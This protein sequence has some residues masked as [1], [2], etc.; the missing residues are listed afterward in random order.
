MQIFLSRL[1][2]VRPE[3]QKQ[4]FLLATILFA[5]MAGLEM[6]SNVAELTFVRRVGVEFLPRLYSFEPI[7]LIGLLLFFGSAIDR[8]GRYRVLFAL[9]GGLALALLLARAL[10]QVN[11]YPIF[12]TLWLAQRIFYGLAPLSF[13]VLCNDVFDIRQSKRLFPSI[14]AAGLAGVTLGNLLTGVLSAWFTAED[15]VLVAAL[16]FG[17]GIIAVEGVRRLKLPPSFVH[18]D[19]MRDKKVSITLPAHL[20]TQPFLQALFLL[21]FILGALEPVLR[22]ELNALA[23]QTFSAE[24]SLISFVGFIKASGAF[25]IV[26]FQLLVA[27]R[28]LDRAGVPATLNILPIGFMILLPLL[29]LFPNIIIGSFVV[30]TL[31]T[32]AAGFHGPAR[33]SALNLFPP[34]ERGRISAF[35]DQLWYVGWFCNSLFLSWASTHLTL[36]QINFAAALIAALWLFILPSLHRRYIDACLKNVSLPIDEAIKSFREIGIKDSRFE[37]G[38]SHAALRSSSPYQRRAVMRTLSPRLSENSHNAEAITTQLQP[39]FRLMVLT[40]PLESALWSKIT[41]EFGQSCARAS[42]ALLELTHDPKQIRAVRRMIGNESPAMRAAGIEALDGLVRL[43]GIKQHLIMLISDA[44]LEEKRAYG[45]KWLKIE[46]AATPEESLRQLSQFPDPTVRLWSQRQLNRNEDPSVELAIKIDSLRRA[47]AFASLT[48][49]ELK[50]VALCAREHQF[51]KGQMICEEGQASVALY[52]IVAGEVELESAARRQ[53]VKRLKEGDTFGE[54][55]MLGDQPYALTTMAL[56]NVSTLII[57]RDTLKELIEYYPNI[58]LG[59][60]RELALRLGQSLDL[61]R[62]E[63]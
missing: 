21:M 12:P 33:N 20:L 18:A 46:S 23:N 53:A 13:W 14:F 26:A 56:S 34:D 49:E 60:M 40:A 25:L 41:H 63:T 1:L 32:F 9:N 17:V 4:F 61:W 19:V 29:G 11:W 28:I 22:Y 44:S 50:A 31:A 42:L 5:M 2:R 43:N 51:E 59:L 57:D 10:M 30:A 38:D 54:V 8:F 37:I 62:E 16:M 6:T 48:E 55:S 36:S 52:V 47:K 24:Q 45:R 39:A 7:I 3:E 27:G 58:A 35:A 15:I